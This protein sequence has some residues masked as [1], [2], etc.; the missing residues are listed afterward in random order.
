MLTG[1]CKVWNSCTSGSNI[2]LHRQERILRFRIWEGCRILVF[3]IELLFFCSQ[4]FQKWFR[5][6][7]CFSL[8][9][10]MTV[11]WLKMVTVLHDCVGGCVDDCV[12]DCVDELLSLLGTPCEECGIFRTLKS[13]LVLSRRSV[14]VGACA[15]GW[16]QGCGILR[17]SES[18]TS[19]RW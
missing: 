5:S 8:S 2:L 12:E 9:V 13:D 17:C 18:T 15:W 4:D 16:G 11:W 7:I 14:L 10:L 1:L 6:R 3:S 19:W